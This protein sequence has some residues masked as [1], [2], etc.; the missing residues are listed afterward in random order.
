MGLRL[1]SVNRPSKEYILQEIRRCAEE[2]GGVPVGRERFA[3]ITGIK[4]SAWEARYW[5]RWNE[6]VLEAGLEPNA[7]N[8]RHLDDDGLIGVLAE[9]TRQLGHFPTMRD[10]R[11]ARYANPAIPSANVFSRVGSRATQLAKVQAYTQARPEYADVAAIVATTSVRAAPPGLPV[12]PD[13]VVTGVVY[14]IRMGEFHKIGKS[15]DP[16][17]RMYELG[18]QLPEK[19]DVVHVIETDD[20]AGIEA[21]WHRRFA[22]QRTN[23]EW[24]RL[25]PG[26]IAAFTRRAYM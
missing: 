17:R 11:I 7:W 26:D 15:N 8:G 4:S 19:H 18:I 24:F 23:G 2:N 6:A 22:A 21:Y 5:A 3:A 16:G 12:E 14:L 1:R 25:S 9:V 20:P 13:Q 10:M